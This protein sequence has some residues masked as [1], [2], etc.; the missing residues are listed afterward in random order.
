MKHYLFSCLL[1]FTLASSL[2]IPAFAQK[3]PR[4]DVIDVP[5]IGEGLCVSN[6][7]QT[8]MVLQR[9]QPIHVW[10]W[11][12]PDEQVMVEFAG[13]EASTKAGKDRAWKVTLPAVSAN[14]K[15]Q[16]M[17]LKGES[18]SLVLDNILIGDV[19]VLG[20]QSNMEFE[21]AKVENGPLEIISANFPEIRI[22]TVPYGQGPELNM[23]FP[24][25]YQWSD[26]SGRHFRKGDWDVCRP[27]IARELSA[28]G[29]VFARRVH[30]ASNVPIGVI[31]ASR[32][33][34]TVETW[35][36]LPVL[37]AMSSEPTKAKLASFDEAAAAWNPQTDLEKRIASHRQW[38]ERQVKEGNPI[39]VDKKQEPG[40]LQP[41][42]IG[43]HN[44]P[45]HCYAGMIAPLSGL[46]VKGAIFHQGYNNAFEGSVGVEMYRDIFPEMIR[47]WRVAFNN[48]EM[49]FGILSLCTD[50]YPQ[51]RD[52]YC[53]KMFNA[54]IEIR[55]AQ[56]QT[57]LDFHN[58]GDRNVGFVS[59]YDLRRRWYHPQL[60]I[61]AGERIARWALATQYGFDSQVQ[62]K[63]PMLVSME[64]GDGTLLLKLDTDV[65]DPQDGVI[66]GFAIAG[67][68]RKFHPANVAYAE[69]GKD[70]RG[71]IQYDYKQLILTSPMVPTPTQFRYA[72]GRNPLANLQAT[73]N[74]D[75]PF[76]TQRSDDWM[77]E[78]VPLGVL[79]EEVSLPLSGGDRNKII[80]ALR[81]QDTARRLKEAEKVIQTN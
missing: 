3:M 65:S 35:T 33:G 40:D 17:V 21:L 63:P 26:W 81:R 45:G 22:L 56:Y 77:M 49:P 57:F 7:F 53:E 69:K 60:K 42:P 55:A 48:P 52:D 76:A 4:E 34:T 50:G 11:A 61:P 44:F 72:W 74:K 41:G 59:T 37:R 80:Q 66:E 51:T 79:G 67:E 29:Y 15:P 12:D 38:V 1:I 9:D 36:P 32:G 6:V 47:A 19:W 16:Q 78:E 2:A 23:G 30:K 54:G 24:R 18:E 73:G 75:L 46:S 62:W 5:A 27:E 58:A 8:N 68:D 25:L 70:N 28:I 20:G 10:G 71:R 31:D 13:S 43:N 64:K 39:P 14:T